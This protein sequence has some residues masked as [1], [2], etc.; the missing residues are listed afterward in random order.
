MEYYLALKRKE[1]LTH[2]TTRMNLRTPCELKQASYK[3]TNLRFY[4]HGA[5]SAGK[6]RGTESGMVVAWGLGRRN[7]GVIYRVRV[8]LM[9]KE[10]VLESGCTITRIHT[11]LPNCTFKIVQ[12]KI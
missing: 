2:T 8:T 11:T 6:F 7:W 9:H 12:V 10:K 4:L 1:I 3:R 5:P